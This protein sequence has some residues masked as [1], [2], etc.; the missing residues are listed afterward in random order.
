MNRKQFIVLLVIVV[1]AAAVASIVYK[2]RDSSWENAPS[3]SGKNILSFQLNDADEVVIK[4]AAGEVHLVKKNDLWT[5]RERAN[6]PADFDQVS[7]L[8]RKMWE[9][10][11]TQDV[12]VGPSQMGRLNLVEPGKGANPGTL[13]AFNAT[14]GK[15]LTAILLG[16]KYLRKSDRPG[17][18]MP[19]FPAGRYVMPEDGRNHVFLVSDSLDEV[20]PMPEKWLSHNFVKPGDVE[21]ISVSGTAQGMNWQVSRNQGTTA[22]TLQDAKPGEQLD[23]AKTGS[24]TSLFSAIGFNDVMAPDTKPDTTGLD[25][26]AT[27]T[28]KTFDHF[29]YVFKIGKAS[30]DNYPVTVTVSAD[31]AKERQAGKDE[32]PE[33]KTRLDKEFQDNRQKLETKLADEKKFEGHI[34]LVSKTSLEPV[35]KERSQLIAAK[36]AATPSPSP[37]AVSPAGTMPTQTPVRATAPAG[38]GVSVTTPPLSAPIPSPSPKATQSPKKH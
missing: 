30:G 18:G 37:A 33:D 35:L 28:V 26:P 11:P 6:Y 5:V 14:G 17:M 15:Q 23:T 27:V 25:K 9:L 8:I 12:K 1:V 20:D 19:E 38:G 7:S 3:L 16:K 24:F 10:K 31:I 36:P 22:W 2:H 4:Q 13:L 29:T 21:S 34:Y 32:K